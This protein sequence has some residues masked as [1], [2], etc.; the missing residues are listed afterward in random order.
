[1][2]DTC[3]ITADWTP[4]SFIHQTVDEIHNRVGEEEVLLAL[5]GGVDSSVAALLMH[6]AIGPRL[7]CFFID[8]GLLRANEYHQVLESYQ[9][10]G[11]K[12][13][14]IDAKSIFMTRFQ[15]LKIP[16]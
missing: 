13:K 4:D 6:K 9:E 14:G 5:S 8:N 12:V 1:M 3:K 15:D 7:H 16:N 11:L 2:I 10:M